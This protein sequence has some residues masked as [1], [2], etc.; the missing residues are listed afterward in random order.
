MN[1]IRFTTVNDLKKCEAAI[2]DLEGQI[3]RIEELM[4]MPETAVD[5]AKLQELTAKQ[6]ELSGK[7]ST[8]YDQWETLAD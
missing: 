3:A 5:V 8:L 6:E 1:I 2:A 4:V 7:L